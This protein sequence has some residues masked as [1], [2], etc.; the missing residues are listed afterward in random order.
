MLMIKIKVGLF[1]DLGN[2]YNSSGRWNCKTNA[3]LET[4]SQ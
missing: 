1:P 3:I 2:A 4:A